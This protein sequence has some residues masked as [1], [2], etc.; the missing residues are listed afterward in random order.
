VQSGSTSTFAWWDVDPKTGNAVGRLT[1]GAGA[2]MVETALPIDNTA[3]YGASL[4][5]DL[6][7][8]VRGRDGCI[9][10]ACASFVDTLGL[11]TG[12][13]ATGA[14]KGIASTVAGVP[15]GLGY[16]AVCGGGD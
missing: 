6:G 5:N 1:G 10:G 13:K 11:L 16:G 4:W 8:C 15:L 2:S 7:G 14:V 9:S 3:M 12:L